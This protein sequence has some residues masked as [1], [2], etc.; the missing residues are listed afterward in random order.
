MTKIA[1]VID[2]FQPP[3]SGTIRH[4][5]QV[6]KCLPRDHYHPYLCLMT[7]SE[8]FLRSFN[9]CPVYVIGITS[10]FHARSYS[11]LYRFA[12]FLRAEKIDIVQTHYRDSNIAGIIAGKWAGVRA[13]VSTR[14]NQ[15]YWHNGFERTLLR[16]L[17]PLVTAFLAN[18]KDTREWLVRAEKVRKEKVH[19]IHNCIDDDFGISNNGAARE[20]YRQELGASKD[21]PV[22]GIVANL[23]PVKAVD[24]FLRAAKI[25]GKQRPKAIFVIVGEG[26]LQ[27]ELERLASHLG[28]RE[29]TVFL[30][31]R[32]DVP[33]LLSAF[34]I[35]VLSSNTESFSNALVEYMAAGLPVV[36]TDVGGAREIVDDGRTGLL[37]PA[38][39]PEIMAERISRLLSDPELR[40]TLGENARRHART[41]FDENRIL[42]QYARFYARLAGQN[43]FPRT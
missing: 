37:V 40:R 13:V 41:A 1:F 27:G 31:R 23:R 4:L 19:V 22:I 43:G 14:R 33:G 30:G 15:G 39:A 28:I 25:V 20:H 10:F 9:L 6:I 26:K 35:G 16:L 7:A 5:S 17:N 24:V 36:S 42:D 21:S 11:R 12:R 3:T 8:E 38:G 18:S 29:K 34:D 2:V 32:L